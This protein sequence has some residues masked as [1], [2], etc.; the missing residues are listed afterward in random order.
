MSLI[1][2]LWSTA[3]GLLPSDGAPDLIISGIWRTVLW[4][5]PSGEELLFETEYVVATIGHQGCAF[6]ATTVE[7]QDL[8]SLVGQHY[9][10]ARNSVL[11]IKIA[12]LDAL[13]G[14]LTVKAHD[15][16][17]EERFDGTP[18]EK[19]RWRASLVA[20][21]TR[22][23]LSEYINRSAACKVALIGVSRLV[24]DEL[25][26]L[27]YD[28]VGFD[29]SPSVVGT[30]LT[31]GE[32]VRHGSELAS[33][34]PKCDA[35]VATGMTLSTGTLEGILALSTKHQIPLILYAQTGANIAP[36]YLALGVSA[37]VAEPIPFYNFEGRST[38]R[39]Y[40]RTLP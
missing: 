27:G 5:R 15:A 37:V 10:A 34:L 29:L 6:T 14:H 33:Q 19:A 32:I 8:K 39:I 35:A 12:V 2:S 4:L 21:E 40:R 20:G 36:W 1:D 28:V 9:S 11:P 23:V 7:D 13:F 16:D 31:N 3:E 30:I 17:R 25:N 24:A 22:R 38:I 26:S 18:P